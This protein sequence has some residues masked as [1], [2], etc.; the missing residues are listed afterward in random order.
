MNR[1]S[2]RLNRLMHNNK[3]LLIAAFFLS[4]AFWAS[5]K[6]NY[7]DNSTRTINDV[8]VTL[9]VTQA[10]ENDFTAF[11]DEQELYVDIVISGKSFDIN[12][13]ALTRDDIIVEAT[14]GY[15]DAAGDK[16]INLT[17]RSNVSGV[18]ILRISPSTVTVF[19]DR[20]A[21]EEFNVEARLT[22]DISTL[23]AEGYVVGKPIASVPTARVKGPATVLDR[24]TKVYFMASVDESKL[25]LTTRQVLPAEIQYDVTPQRNAAFLTCENVGTAANPATIDIPVT[26]EE[27]VP[28]VVKFINQPSAFETN[29]PDVRISPEK[30]VINNTEET[31]T[32]FNVGTVDFKKLKN[33]VNT[34]EFTVDEKSAALLQDPTQT[35][36]SVR[37]D[38]SEF[39]KRTLDLSGNSVEFLSRAEGFD[40]LASL[41]SSGLETVTVIG[42]QESLALLKPEDLRIEINVSSLDTAK[43]GYQRVEIS[44]IS[45][46]SDQITDC[47]VYGTYQARVRVSAK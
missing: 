30:V 9:D 20:L 29:P 25:P 21:S 27:A 33:G 2:S 10:E 22:N 34:F 37:I 6:V 7:S 19:F 14:A 17:A 24:L 5:I 16:T 8:K 13:Y 11:F 12:S 38:L 32:S 4:I 3:F 23:A 45:I 46:L 42:S 15:V 26:K 35:E 39:S 1:D 43:S 18:E 40:Y 36:F 28:T 44:N 31:Y 41:K 47:W